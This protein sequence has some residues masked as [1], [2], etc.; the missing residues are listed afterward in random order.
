MTYREFKQA[1]EVFGFGERVTLGQIKARHR[2]LAK[3]YHPD[4]GNETDSE[5]IRN[6]NWAYE[7][8]TTYCE[9]YRYCLTEEEYLEQVPEERLR[10]Q[11][12]EDPAWGGSNSSS[13]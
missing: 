13:N 11:F 2:E 9:N 10:R 6:V 12:A 4:H 1:I 3:T 5:V 7:V 8:L